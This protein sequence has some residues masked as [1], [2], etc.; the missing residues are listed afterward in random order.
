MIKISI[1]HGLI[2]HFASISIP[3][4]WLDTTP[5]S[6]SYS[7]LGKMHQWC[8]KRQICIRVIAVHKGL[9]HNNLIADAYHFHIELTGNTT[10]ETEVEFKLKWL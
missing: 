7:V 5:R 2:H 4:E 9:P 8:M 6:Y 10:D 1:S 3:G